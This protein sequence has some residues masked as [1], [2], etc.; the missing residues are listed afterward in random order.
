[1]RR[2]H[3]VVSL[4][5]ISVYSDLESSFTKAA[6]YIKR[7]NPTLSDGIKAIKDLN[8]SLLFIFSAFLV[9]YVD[10]IIA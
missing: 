1:M 3:H 5:N 6:L 9:T 7:L 10:L 2:F 4:F 8:P